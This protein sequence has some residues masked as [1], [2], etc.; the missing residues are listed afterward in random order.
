MKRKTYY[1]THAQH[2]TKT[3]PLIF[4][5]TATTMNY[6]SINESNKQKQKSM[7]PNE[8]TKANIQKYSPSPSP[9][10]SPSPS[11]SPSPSQ[12]MVDNK[13]FPKMYYK[14]HNMWKIQ[15]ECYSN[16]LMFSRD[17]HIG[18]VAQLMRN[19]FREYETSPTHKDKS[20]EYNIISFFK[21]KYNEQKSTMIFHPRF[22]KT[23]LW[24]YNMREEDHLPR[25]QRDLERLYEFVDVLFIGQCCK[26]HLGLKPYLMQHMNICV[27]FF[28][29][30]MSKTD[31]A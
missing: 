11:P 9:S 15:E 22:M 20:T 31:K 17:P 3:M 28:I 16:Y 6:N 24:I 21:E 25:T 10:Q 2:S 29:Y 1:D 5:T 8:L 13:E 7:K 19:V 23:T 14:M 18:N 12:A 26:N 30:M 4:T 27:C